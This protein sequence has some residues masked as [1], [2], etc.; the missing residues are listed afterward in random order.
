VAWEQ[1][2]GFP[3]GELDN[4]HFFYSL[5]K[6]GNNFTHKGTEFIKYG[7]HHWV[8]FILKVE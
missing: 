1:K 3:S 5:M 6:W 8:S 2:E 7:L 4:F